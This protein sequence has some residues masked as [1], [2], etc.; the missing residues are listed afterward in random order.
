MTMEMAPRHD[1]AGAAF[2]TAQEREYY[3]ATE[4]GAERL[5]QMIEDY[6]ARRGAIVNV[7][8]V[9]EG[10]VMAMRGARFDV[11][12]D[13]VNALPIGWNSTQ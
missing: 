11:R 13:M 9:S 6:W 12:S 2:L 7:R 10:F 4:Q 1:G 3:N 5:K 8:V